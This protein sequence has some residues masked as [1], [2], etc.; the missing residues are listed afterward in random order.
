MATEIGKN[1]CNKGNYL[2]GNVP[3]QNTNAPGNTL[4]MIQQ[5]LL[6]EEAPDEIGVMV[7]TQGL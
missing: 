3:G 1:N 6:F 5:P 7:R 4:I 2:P